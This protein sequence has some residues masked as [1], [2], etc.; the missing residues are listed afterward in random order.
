MQVKEIMITE[1]KTISISSTIKDAAQKMTE[2]RIGS[3]VAVTDSKLAGI[4]TERDILSKV[5]ALSKQSAK[6]K[7]KD[8]MTKEVVMIDPEKDIMDAAEVMMEK[9]IKKL[10]VV[11]KNQL[12]GIV[13]AWDICMAEPKLIEQIGELIQLSDKKKMVAG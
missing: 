13:T 7:V 9:R 8:V 3:L 12:V 5:V 10:P 4:L 1:V 11:I 2:N 6:M